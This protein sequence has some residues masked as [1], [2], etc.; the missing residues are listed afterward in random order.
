MPQKLKKK[1]GASDDSVNDS[2][3]NY[4]EDSERSEDSDESDCDRSDNH[5]EYDGSSSAPTHRSRVSARPER[6]NARRVGRPVSAARSDDEDDLD[7]AS[8][9]LASLDQGNR[10][11]PLEMKTW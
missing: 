2:D 1:A 10:Q 11:P 8:T 3:D 9:A 7:A 5:E 4:H 6:R